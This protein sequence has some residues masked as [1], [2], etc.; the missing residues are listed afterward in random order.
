MFFSF[1]SGFGFGRGNQVVYED[2][3]PSLS[4]GLSSYDFGSKDTGTNTDYI[5]TL[6]NSGNEVAEDVTVAV[7]GTG[8]SLL[9]SAGPFNIAADG[10]YASITVRFSPSA[11]GSATGALTVSWPEQDDI[12]VTLAGE[13]VGAAGLAMDHVTVRFA[14]Y[15]AG[16]TYY[17][18]VYDSTGALVATSSAGTTVANDTAVTTSISGTLTD[19]ETYKLAFIASG[20]VDVG[21][22][23]G[24]T[25]RNAN[26]AYPTMPTTLPSESSTVSNTMCI[27]VYDSSNNMILGTDAS[28]TGVVVYANEYY[29]IWTQTGYEA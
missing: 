1:G 25:S 28:R 13:G 20:S 11:A 22:V 8:F 17:V 3:L 29:T 15:G 19:G 18:G 9:S 4:F 2:L 16:S 7:T 27:A 26:S 24:T 23:S 12:T 10:G 21:G 5:F 14:T 6:T